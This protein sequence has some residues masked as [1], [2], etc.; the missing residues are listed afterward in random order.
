M[1]QRTSGLLFLWYHR[2]IFPVVM[3]ILK[4]TFSLLSVFFLL[5]AAVFLFFFAVS[6]KGLPNPESFDARQITQSTKIYDRS[7]KILLYEIYGEEKRTVI[8]YS[9]IPDYAKKAAIAI[10][11][12]NFYSHAAFDWRSLVR[13]LVANLQHG[14]IVQGGS[15]ITQQLAKNVFLSSEKTLTRKVRE[16]V[17][18]FQLEKRYTKDKILDLYLNQ[19]PYGA[20]AYGIEAASQTYFNKSAKEISLAEAAL[21]ASLPKAPSYYSPYGAHTDELAQRKNLVLEK[22]FSLGYIS[23]EEKTAAAKEKMILTPQT[24]SIKAP[25]FIHSV[26]EYLNNRYGEDYVRSAGLKVVT[27]LDWN[28]QQTAEKVVTEGVQRNTELYQGKN[29]ALVAQDARTGQ[30]LALVGSKDYFDADND[31]NFNVATQGLRQPGSSIKPFAYITAFKKGFT[32]ET[33]LFDLETEFDTT[34]IEDKSYKPAN[35]DEQFR[36]PVTFR[37]ALAQSINVPSVKVLYL[38]G[39]GPTLKTA[40]D[41]GI[42]TLT[43]KS[44]YGLSLALG[45]GEVKLYDLVGAYSVFSQEGIKH[46]QAL[47]LK[48]T[49]SNN[50]VLEEYQDKSDRVIDAQ[51]PRLI[52]DILS[53][54]DARRALFQNSLGL[55]TY[56]GYEVA[57]KTGTTND[58]RDAWAMGYTPSLV[59]GV[60]AGNNDN[61]PMQKKGGSILAAVPIWHDFMVEALKTQPAEIFSRPESIYVNKPILNGQYVINNQVHDILYYI[62]KNDPQGPAPTDPSADS[63]FEN[64]E[65]VVLEWAQQN[66]D[67]IQFAQS[68]INNAADTINIDLANPRNGDFVASP[69]TVD[70][71]IKSPTDISKIEIYVNEKLVQQ[72][73]G[74]FGKDY[75]Y[76]TQISPDLELQNLFKFKVYNTNNQTSEKEVIVFKR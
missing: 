64:W 44:R 20:N 15:T 65:K 38:A 36:G 5:G 18:S 27:A 42:T 59:V 31:G 71:K 72:N 54:I 69:M 63:Q 35:F 9:V 51:Y 47:V 75:V 61:Q 67:K 41:F 24:Q 60:W 55:T 10:E 39:I 58:Y 66:P 1:Q 6:V 14:R 74:N 21:L 76:Q 52:N 48:I 46:N 40:Q 11:D 3:K 70:A 25:H 2:K 8:P 43:E 68:Q 19:I 53:D 12:E 34:G 13:A 37:Q 26:I 33:I 73:S 23:E 49:D 57:L 62:S 4:R 50:K 16:L 17:L 29:A 28:L 45:G 7:E 32:P 30:I 56:P 22:M